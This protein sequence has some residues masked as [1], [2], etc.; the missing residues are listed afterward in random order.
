GETAP[1]V[2]YRVYLT[3][4]DSIGLSNTTFFDILP[5][6][7]QITLQTNIPGLSLTLDGEPQNVPETVTGV[8]NL[9]RTLQ[10][11]GVQT[12]NGKTYVFTGWSDGGAATHNISFP[13]SPTTYTA[14]YVEG[15]VTMVSSMPF[16]SGTNGWGPVERNLSNG[17]KK[18]GDGNLLTLN[19][20]TY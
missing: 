3:V 11:P 18:A 1:H 13:S 16:A 17:Q 4:T 14:N 6:E 7:S 15:F 2:W 19:G 5:V 9:Q 8:V 10:A 12:L 20:V